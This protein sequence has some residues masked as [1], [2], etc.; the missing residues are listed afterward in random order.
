MCAPVSYYRCSLST[1]GHGAA[2]NDNCGLIL[3]C[4]C[5]AAPASRDRKATAALKGNIRDRLPDEGMGE[6]DDRDAPGADEGLTADEPV[7]E[8]MADPGAPM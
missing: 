8:L 2:R 5:V 4:G 7:I 6:D 1:D 3:S